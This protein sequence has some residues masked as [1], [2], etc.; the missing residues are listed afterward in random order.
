V[1][2]DVLAAQGE[3]FH[4]VAGIIHA[5]GAACALALGVIEATYKGS[6]VGRFLARLFPKLVSPGTGRLLAAAALVGGGVVLSATA[7]RST[8]L[9]TRGGTPSEQSG[10]SPHSGLSTDDGTLTE[11]GGQV[12]VIP[13]FINSTDRRAPI[14]VDVATGDGLGAPTRSVRVERYG[15]DAQDRTLQLLGD[16]KPDGVT[17]V[18]RS[19]FDRFL[20]E[21]KFSESGMVSQESAIRVGRQLGARYVLLGEIKKLSITDR[22]GA[23]PDGQP[24]STFVAETEISFKLQ[25]VETGE[26]VGTAEAAG[27]CTALTRLPD[28]D[29]ISSAF[30]KAFEMLSKDPKMSAALKKLAAMTE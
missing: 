3:T 2:A 20:D 16:I 28:A 14:D 30:D 7:L 29:M 12:L 22:H 1:S 19:R 21:F 6:R 9:L 25:D 8:P 13:P 17:L 5:G 18:D 26:V 24:L 27:R 23:S 10:Q 15:R 11:M 4:D